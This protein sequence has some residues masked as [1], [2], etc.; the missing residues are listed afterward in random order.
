MA[1]KLSDPPRKPSSRAYLRNGCLIRTMLNAVRAANRGYGIEILSRMHD[2]TPPDL[3]INGVIVRVHDH[4]LIGFAF[5]RWRSQVNVVDSR[6][7]SA[8]FSTL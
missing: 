7:N 6:F 5:F 1:T 8:G 3:L 2:E 4:T